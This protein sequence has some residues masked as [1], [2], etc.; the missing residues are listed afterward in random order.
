MKNIDISQIVDPTSLQ[1]FTGNSLKFLQ[2]YNAENLAA[3]I[4]A[5]VIGNLGSYSLTVPYVI[6]GCVVSDAGKDVTAGEIFYG[7]KYFTTTAVNGSTNVARFI[8]TKTQDATADPLEFTDGASKTVHDIFTYVAT[9]VASGGDFTSAN[10]VSLY[11]SKYSDDKYLATLSSSSTSYATITGL[12]VT[13]P[14]D[15]KTR[16]CWIT[17]NT[18]FNYSSS[19]ANGA[20]LQ[21]WDGSAELRATRCFLSVVS[22][23]VDT[24]ILQMTVTYKGDIPPNTTISARVKMVNSASSNYVDS[25]LSIME[26]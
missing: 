22:V 17:A 25:S 12:T 8:L 21:L 1:P 24:A 6:N 26:I 11:G 18:T 15:G 9:D 4:E 16:T 10:L 13:T 19:V 3:I 23:N 2:D 7:G 5:I 14:N 20:F